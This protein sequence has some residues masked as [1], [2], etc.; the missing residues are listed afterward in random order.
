MFSTSKLYPR[1]SGVRFAASHFFQNKLANNSVSEALWAAPL[2]VVL[3]IVF[4]DTHP[5]YS[6]NDSEMDMAC[7]IR[8]PFRGEYANNMPTHN[9]SYD[10]HNGI[11]SFPYGL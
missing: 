6:I 2:N 3:P 10:L 7:R 9:D 11:A 4:S 1:D 5:Q 8:M